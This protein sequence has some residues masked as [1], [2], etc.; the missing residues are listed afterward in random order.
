MNTFC[1]RGVPPHS[2]YDNDILRQ[3]LLNLRSQQVL[4]RSRPCSSSY[5]DRQS[6]GLC[7]FDNNLGCWGIRLERR[8]ASVI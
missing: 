7:C 1:Y 5:L 6:Y 4:R 2:V 3:L 8:R